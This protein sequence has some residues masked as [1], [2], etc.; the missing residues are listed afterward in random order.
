VL[1]PLQQ[2]Y[3]PADYPQMLIGLDSPDD[4]AAYRLNDAQAIVVTT[5]FFT[6][7]VDDPYTYG[8]IAAANSLSDVYAMGATPLLALNLVALPKN[9][10]TEMSQAIIRG[11]AEKAL[12]AQCVIAG[13][14]TIQDDE[15]KVG[16]AVVGLA[17]PDKLLRK[18]GATPG[19]VLYLTKPIGTGVISTAAKSDLADATHLNNA[20][21]WMSTLNRVPSQ[22]ALQAGVGAAT[23]ITGFG[24][25]GHGVELANASGVTLEINWPQV[26][27]LDGAATYADE[28]LFPGGTSDNKLAFEEQVRFA[29]TVNE[30]AQML[31]FDA[32]TSGGL[33]VAVPERTHTDFAARMTAEGAACWEIGRVLPREDGIAIRVTGT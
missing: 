23:D 27:L 26:P 2:L 19:E 3:N 22:L 13:G 17:H 8:S 31:L 24:L 15:P 14:H 16:L 1:R 6:P 32:Q 10:P 4:A 18:S 7:I 5:D 12:E 30:Q 11:M 25:L 20:T 21:A 33:L 9:L 28:W 29:D